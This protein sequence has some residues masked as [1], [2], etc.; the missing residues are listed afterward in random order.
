MNYPISLKIL[1]IFQRMLRVSPFARRFCLCHG[2]ALPSW[3][4]QSSYALR[5]NG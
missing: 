5:Q 4:V 3:Q 2:F 1:W